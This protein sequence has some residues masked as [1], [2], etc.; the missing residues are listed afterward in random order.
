MTGWDGVPWVIG[1]QGVKHTSNIARTLAFAAFGGQ[2]GIV[3]TRDLEV[4]P[5]SPAS[6]DVRVMP[7][8][9]AIL[10]HNAGA[11]YE[12]YATRLP[13]GGDPELVTIAPT[14][15]SAGRCDLIIAVVENPW[16][17]EADYPKPTAQQIA[18]G[19]AV[20]V[21][22]RVL[23]MS[24]S[25][26][27]PT[28]GEIAAR[29]G[30]RSAIPLASVLVPQATGTIQASMI[31][32]QRAIAQ[33]RQQNEMVVVNPVETVVLTGTT[34]KTI[35]FA[36]VLAPTWATHCTVRAMLAGA[37]YPNPGTAGGV[38]ISTTSGATVRYGEQVLFDS[39][40]T[41]PDRI[42]LMAA[43]RDIPLSDDARGVTLRVAMEGSK[44][45]GQQAVT[46]DR[47]TAVAFDVVFKA[48][49]ESNFPALNFA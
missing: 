9:A 42:G 18:D 28:P 44:S 39:Q 7:G 20:F 40:S 32:S 22:T 41:N 5:T 37:K 36:D 49:P 1:G 21:R 29:I 45:S 27:H 11:K 10:N 17:D 16:V 47:Y 34:Y 4:A 30:A 14:G 25:T 33:F 3:G 38:R 46:I 6:G 43:G 26:R 8:A 15:A 23:T 12:A 2:E 19:T 48:K 35:A 31:R 13:P 24:N